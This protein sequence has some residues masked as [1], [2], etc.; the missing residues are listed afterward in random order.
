MRTQNPSSRSI[1]CSAAPIEPLEPRQFL[2]AGQIDPTF[3][4][5]GVTYVS[6]AQTIQSH[7]VAAAKAPSGKIV[8]ILSDNSLVRLNADGSL[9]TTFSN[10][11][12]AYAASILAVDS[13][14][15][16]YLASFD[17]P[18]VT[19]LLPDGS[20]DHSFDQ[21]A[22]YVSPQLTRHG[23]RDFHPSNIAIDPAGKVFVCGEINNRFAV[24]KL[25]PDGGLDPTFGYGGDAVFTFT[26]H[27][28]AQLA[29]AAAVAF[30]SDGNVIAAGGGE[31][32]LELVR[33]KS[34][35]LPDTSFGQGGGVRVSMS[36]QVAGLRAVAVGKD[37]SIFAA[38]GT[39][40]SSNTAGPNM[41]VLHVLNDGTLDR[42]FG[43]NGRVTVSNNDAGDL[44]DFE[45]T[46]AGLQPLPDDHLLVVAGVTSYP[47]L[48]STFPPA[49]RY[50]AGS[51][52][53]L[54]R[55]NANGLADAD[56]GT[57]LGSDIPGR[58]APP[59][60]RFLAATQPAS[61]FVGRANG[62]FL[63]A[64]RGSARQAPDEQPTTVAF[65]AD[66]NFDQ[67]FG[68]RGTSTLTR[69]TTPQF[70]S[71]QITT[72]PDAGQPI[73]FTVNSQS[74]QPTV[75]QLTADGI[76]Q[77]A[78]P[79][80][81]VAIQ[82]DG[83]Y[84]AQYFKY[85]HFTELMRFNP[86]GTLDKTFGHDGAIRFDVT[87]GFDQISVDQLL[88]RPDGSLVISVFQEYRFIETDQTA[89]TIYL[90]GAN[91]KIIASKISPQ[92][93]TG[94]FSDYAADY[95]SMALTP[96]GDVLLINSQQIY[97]TTPVVP[98][99]QNL[100][101]LSGTDLSPLAAF[102][103]PAI[104]S[105]LLAD[106]LDVSTDGTIRVSGIDSATQNTRITADFNP[107]G[108]QNT[109]YGTNGIVTTPDPAQ[110]SALLFTPDG[111]RL[112][113]VRDHRGVIYVTRYTPQGTLDPT[114]GNAGI[115]TIYFARSGG[116][117]SV[118]LA[119]QQTNQGPALLV[120]G[121]IEFWTARGHPNFN[122]A[123]FLTRLEL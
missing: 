57:A 37:G 34:N 45:V 33:F 112:T 30:D 23:A 92:S 82:S 58:G 39:P 2:S 111:S 43:T 7:V 29:G 63:V 14:S 4:T 118:S 96:Q 90:A 114:F 79:L 18:E 12:F 60:W 5:D 94:P 62:I 95:G 106:Q 46:A 78:L 42:A 81:P 52:I 59:N 101:K 67:S 110:A 17:A 41:L 26:R 15:R 50:T 32:W 115:A 6:P 66:G 120:F 88:I 38:G 107:D 1:Q 22:N 54:A 99:N 83:K 74:R 13:Q 27:G 70:S 8:E 72:G 11:A 117:P 76:V 55:L 91:G 61:A 28:H 36:T 3:G 56:F 113:A 119:L 100:L 71:A 85:N 25:K 47:A 21:N 116:F 103:Q 75:A 98:L 122:N 80:K 77:H 121:G 49:N 65:T 104:P 93:P 53:L 108:T 51:G 87:P 48:L 10:G 31:R 16:I 35:G 97:I 102:G 73:L 44:L 123:A 20:I 105:T 24:I 64:I 89:R 9:D 40:R 19:R 68:H 86:D 84:Y 109:A 69:P